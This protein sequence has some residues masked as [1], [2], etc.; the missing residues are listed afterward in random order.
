MKSIKSDFIQNLQNYV[1]IQNEDDRNFAFEQYKVL[2]DSLNNM[3]QVRENSNNFW[4]T[5]N[6][7]L[8]SSIAYLRSLENVS[9][10]QHTFLVWSVL[11]LGCFLA[12]SWIRSL[13]S[14]KASIDICYNLLIEIEK[15][16]PAKIFTIRVASLHRLADK[17]S[18]TLK[19]MLVPC[20]F[21]LGYTIFAIIIIYFPHTILEAT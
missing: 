19:E 10:G 20:L 18:L 13:L 7:L 4:T 21:L 6:S 8:I 12:G 9:Q 5:L 11:I 17:G 3:N 14:I 16:L 1:H 2:A 15:Y